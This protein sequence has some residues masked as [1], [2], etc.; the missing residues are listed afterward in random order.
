MSIDRLHKLYEERF[1][2]YLGRLKTQFIVIG[3]IAAL[4]SLLLGHSVG[5]RSCE[6]P[7]LEHEQPKI[8][9]IV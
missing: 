4:S 1:Y 8:G 9:D 7:K 3:S 5:K 6:S 2:K